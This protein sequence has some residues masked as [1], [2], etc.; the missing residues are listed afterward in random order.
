[1]KNEIKEALLK[2]FCP[3]E[4]LIEYW[5]VPVDNFQFVTADFYQK[6]E[7]ELTARKIPSLEI[8]RVEL[9]EGGLLS[10]K[11]EFLRLRRER[12]VFNICAAPFGTSYF[13]SFR[14][15]EL[16]LG[17]KPTQLL[18][19]IIGIAITFALLAKL[20]GTIFGFIALLAVLGGGIYVVRNS[21]ALGLKNLDAML[22]KTPVIG[23]LY[24]VFIRKDTYYRQDTRLMY[25]TTVNSITEMLVQEIT[26]A[27]GIKLL[28]QYNR[29]PPGADFYQ[30]TT[31]RLDGNDGTPK[32]SSV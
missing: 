15:V 16:P 17:I 31:K 30:T 11:R 10:D 22:I 7:K 20:L 28:K 32:S 4:E 23:P 25:F 24:E 5:Y 2:F 9:S 13:F 18:I 27:K 8:S 6:I 29:K 21:V 1:M 26:A 3:K 12:L 14:F 19:F